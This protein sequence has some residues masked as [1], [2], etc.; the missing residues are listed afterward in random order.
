MTTTI[1]QAAAAAVAADATWKTICALE[2]IPVLGARVVRS[3]AGDIAVFRNAEDEV[4]AL[5]D[6]CAHK[7]GPLSQGIVHGREVTCPLHGWKFHLD[8]GAA[9]APDV[10]HTQPFEVK[11]VDGRVLLKA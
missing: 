11:L 7:G 2:D 10:G 8:S 3:N 6:K 1:D 5:R 9:L 4:F